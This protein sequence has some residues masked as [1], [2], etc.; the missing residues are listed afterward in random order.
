MGRATWRKWAV[1]IGGVLVV[2]VLAFT[3]LKP[4]QSALAEEEVR[5][6]IG[7]QFAGTIQAFVHT[8]QN[9]VEVYQVTIL[10][11]AGLYGVLVDPY[12]GEILSLEQLADRKQI[13]PGENEGN[14]PGNSRLSVEQVKELIAGMV[15]EDVTIV[16][17]E[18]RQ[19][20]ERPF[21]AVVIEQ[22]EGSGKIEIDAI[23]GEVLN[24]QVEEEPEK[25]RPGDEQP[26]QTITKQEAERIALEQVSGHVEDVDLEDEDGRLLYEV[27]IEIEGQDGD[28]ATVLIDAVTGEVITIIWED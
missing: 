9:G 7:E 28:E 4:S 19:R 2:T 8:K 16:E 10:T 27:E 6:S 17:I 21:Y 5:A 25:G 23:S 22:R 20:N 14:A 26:A 18:Q 13:E 1:V 3:F 11:E 15:E 12:S 24:Y